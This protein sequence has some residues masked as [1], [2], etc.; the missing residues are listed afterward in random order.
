MEFPIKMLVSFVPSVT[1]TFL[2]FYM[3][4]SFR[5]FAHF[6]IDWRTGVGWLAW[7]ISPRLGSMLKLQELDLRNRLGLVSSFIFNFFMRQVIHKI[8]GRWCRGKW[9]KKKKKKGP[10]QKGVG[11][12][13]VVIKMGVVS[14]PFCVAAPHRNI[15]CG[16]TRFVISSQICG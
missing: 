14:V 4:T 13:G 2:V 16:R 5:L 7:D 6:W 15:L 1:W 9:I 3:R 12:D 8:F 10:E 11:K